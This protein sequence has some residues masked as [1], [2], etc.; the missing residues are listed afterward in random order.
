MEVHLVKPQV[1]VDDVFELDIERVARTGNLDVAGKNGEAQRACFGQKFRAEGV[2]SKAYGSV[3]YGFH[4][5]G[6]AVVLQVDRGQ[7]EQHG[8]QSGQ[9]AEASQRAPEGEAYG[10]RRQR[11]GQRSSSDPVPAPGA[12]K[13]SVQI[14]PCSVQP[15]GIAPVI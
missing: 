13:S 2:V 9:Y 10:V 5:S 4:F 1:A 12:A 8:Y 14:S 15:G 11:G 3:H 6:E 7:G